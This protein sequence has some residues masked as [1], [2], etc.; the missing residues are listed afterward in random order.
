M[1]DGDA[2]AL[3]G[4]REA[5]DQVFAAPPA[6]AR[7]EEVALLRMRAGAEPVAIRVLQAAGLLQ[8]RRI[9]PV[10]GRRRELLGV[11][12][13]R[14]RVI[15]VYSAARLIGVPETGEP[16]WLV[17]CGDGGLAIAFTAFD[18]HLVLPAANLA[19]ARGGE[20]AH[21]AELADASGA[22]LPVLSMPSLVRAITASVV[23]GP[24]PR[25]AGP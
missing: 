25:S 11:A 10:P 18:G 12:G 3:S 6:P 15:P 16:R 7:R 24:N 1:R 8:G 14:G 21:V 2:S 17:L 22:L 20:R 13:L 9:V 4:L 23:Q 19:P 5:F